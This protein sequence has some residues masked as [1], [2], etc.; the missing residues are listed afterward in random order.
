MK[1]LLVLPARNEAE[2]LPTLIDELRA[3]YPHY[4][5]LIVDDQSSDS[6]SQVA[7]LH[8]AAV[9]ELPF[10]LGIGGAEQTGFLYAL[11]HG[12]DEV[13]RLDGD[14]QHPPE[15]VQALLHALRDGQ[16]DVVIGSRFLKSEGFRSSRLRRVGIRWL[17]L[18]SSTLARQRITDST[19]GFRA[20]RRNA[21]EFLAS[22]NPQDY[23]EPESVV[24][25]TRNGFG[26]AEV[27]VMM[28]ERQEGK[29]SIAGLQ[30]VY[31]MLKTT[32]A[33]LVT[34]LR[35]PVRRAVSQRDGE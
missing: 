3:R 7:R 5:V 26:I 17:A 28:R 13:V 16:A 9:V 21:F 34:A 22:Y 8:G 12:Y 11:R 19:S 23:P 20:F 15:A 1:T 27:P 4:D 2:N 6:T 30:A 24:L 18:L 32:L 33:L 25:L 14:G 10:N 29:S 35:Q 31:Y